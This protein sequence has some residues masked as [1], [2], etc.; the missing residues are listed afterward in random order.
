MLKYKYAGHTIVLMLHN[1]KEI[2]Y[3]PINKQQVFSA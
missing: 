2:I 3:L 1:D